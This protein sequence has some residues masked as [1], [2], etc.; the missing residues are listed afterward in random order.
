MKAS[1]AIAAGL[2]LLTSSVFAQS[3]DAPMHKRLG[4]AKHHARLGRGM[5]S[6]S[7]AIS[8]VVGSDIKTTSYGEVIVPPMQIIDVKE[9]PAPVSSKEVL[10]KQNTSPSAPVKP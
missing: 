7:G 6:E 9:Q 3:S 10:P 1:F 4:M 8:V 2:L 5:R